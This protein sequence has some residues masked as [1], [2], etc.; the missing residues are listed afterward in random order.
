[1]LILMNI[2]NDLLVITRNWW[3]RETHIEH[4]YLSANWFLNS[5][6]NVFNR[7]SSIN[8]YLGRKPFELSA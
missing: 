6:L 7:E 4:K 8:L 3:L 2:L 5:F 1:M